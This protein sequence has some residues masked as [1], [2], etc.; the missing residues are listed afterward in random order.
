MSQDQGAPDNIPPCLGSDPRIPRGGDRE[1]VLVLDVKPLSV[2][3]EEAAAYW[4]DQ[5]KLET[6]PPEPW[7]PV[8]PPAGGVLNKQSRSS[9]PFLDTMGDFCR[10][11]SDVVFRIPRDWDRADNPPRGFFHF[12]RGTSTTA[13]L[14]VSH[15]CDNIGASEP[16]RCVDKQDLSS[17]FVTFDRGV[18]P[19]LRAWDGTRVHPSQRSVYPLSNACEEGELTTT[20]HRSRSTCQF[21]GAF[22]AAVCVPG[23]ILPRE[24]FRQR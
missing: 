1:I 8:R 24:E 9:Y 12:V 10:V 20:F 19:K 16:F 18:D 17:W 4:S 2:S 14:V 11:P 7:I 21:L 23:V 15:S 3:Y 22:F 6:P 13:L 5:C